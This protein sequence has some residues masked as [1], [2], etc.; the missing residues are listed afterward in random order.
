MHKLAFRSISTACYLHLSRTAT[1]YCK[2]SSV[3]TPLSYKTSLRNMTLFNL[4]SCRDMLTAI[5]QYILSQITGTSPI[6]P[7]FSFR[8]L[9]LR[10]SKYWIGLFTF[11]ASNSPLLLALPLVSYKQQTLD[12]TVRFLRHH[13]SVQHGLFPYTVLCT[14]RTPI[15]I[16]LCSK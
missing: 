13:Y 5:V 4:I 16:N 9:F 3:V 8:L 7:F 14:N 12:C 10:N 15:L 1:V 6:F 11:F 2:L